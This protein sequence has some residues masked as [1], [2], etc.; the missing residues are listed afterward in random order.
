MGI[1][2]HLEKYSRAPL[3]CFKSVLSF[4]YIHFEKIKGTNFSLE[5]LGQ[6]FTMVLVFNTNILIET[7]DKIFLQSGESSKFA[8]KA[9]CWGIIFVK[10]KLDK[11]FIYR[12]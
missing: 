1:D 8:V 10:Q 9:Y 4:V 12:I 2:K 7:K 11:I 5:T 3:Y 6:V